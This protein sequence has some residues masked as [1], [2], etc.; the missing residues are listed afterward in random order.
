MFVRLKCPL[1]IRLT[2]FL[3]HRHGAKLWDVKG[4]NEPL[5][6]IYIQ[7]YVL[8]LWR[9]INI[10]EPYNLRATCVLSRLLAAHSDADVPA[11]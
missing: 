7:V 6:D 5:R 10:I 11:M 8:G 1:K 3:F 4:S 2:L 9:N